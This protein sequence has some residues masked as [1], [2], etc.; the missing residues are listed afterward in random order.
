[1]RLAF[2]R[3]PEGNAKKGLAEFDPALLAGWFISFID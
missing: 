3:V 1:M 2:F